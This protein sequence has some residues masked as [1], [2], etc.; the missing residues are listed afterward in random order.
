M[1]DKQVIALYIRVST[2]EQVQGFSLEAQKAALYDYCQIRKLDIYKLYVDAGRSGKSISGR[3]SLTEMLEDARKGHFQQVICLRLNRLSRNL[4]DLLHITELFEQYGITLHSLTENLQTD[5]PMGK[6]S[7]QML[8]S[9]A[10][11]ERQQSAQNTSLGM[12][13]RNRLGKWNSGNQVLGYRCIPNPVNRHLSYVE[14]IPDE[15]ELVRTIFTWYAS[16]LGLK[17]ITNHLNKNGQRTKKGKMFQ[18]VSVRG[19]LT[20]VNYI[21]KISY[22]DKVIPEHKK[23][24]DGEHE[25]IV[26]K[27]LWD[28]VQQQ[29]ALRSRP[30]SKR[31]NHTFLLTGLLKCPACG[32]S[33]IASHVSRKRKNK[34]RT[35]SYYYICSL[36]ASKG[37]SA[38]QPYHIR[39]DQAENRVRKHVQ[40]FFA[41]PVI[42]EQLVMKLNDRRDKKLQPFRQQLK[43]NETQIASLKKR[44]LR[45]YELFEDGHINSKELKI[46]LGRLQS[47]MASL[48]QERQKLEQKIAEEPAQ[49]IPLE[50]IRRVLA[51]FKPVLQHAAPTQ[52]K[53][54]FR[55]MLAKVTLPADRDITRMTIQGSTALLNLEIPTN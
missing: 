44:N 47:E 8:G 11:H 28:K 19:I 36:Y 12:Q 51:D 52:Q 10:E 24:V 46:K 40:R 39:A 33:M 2:E 26:S 29:L 55:S 42:A 53:A 49:P 4:N 30:P 31:I 27:E 16:G 7:L 32:S 50:H 23:I 38:C 41:N 54:L 21:G 17:A 35:I 3:P 13:R 15:A 25:P 18:S 20:N 45:C 43:E 48:E 34:A 6:F 1:I 37:Y 5:S 14:N 9:I 22:T